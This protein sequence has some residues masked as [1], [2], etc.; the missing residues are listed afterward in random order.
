MACLAQMVKYLS[1]PEN[2]PH[3]L[4]FRLQEASSYEKASATS[5]KRAATNAASLPKALVSRELG[6]VFLVQEKTDCVTW[7]NFAAW[8]CCNFDDA[9]MGYSA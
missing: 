5:C 7:E 4:E 8:N 2:Q 1:V 9:G 6:V 3:V